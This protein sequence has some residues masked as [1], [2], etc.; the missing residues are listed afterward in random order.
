MERLNI[1]LLTYCYPP[2]KFPRSVQISHLVQYLRKDFNITVVTSEPENEGDPSLLSFTPLDNV[3]YAPKSNF[4]KIIERSKGHRIKKEI[5]PD[6]QYLWHFDLFRKAR[7]LIDDSSPDVIITFG[8]PMSTHIAGLKLKRKF[9]HIKWLAHF[10]DPWVDN[11]FNDY[12]AWTKWINK[13]YQDS[14]LKSA[15]R[16]IFTSQE[17]IDLVTKYYSEEVRKKSICLPHI[18]NQALYFHQSDHT[19]EKIILRYIGNFYGNRQP[20]SFLKALKLLS[21]EQRAQLRVEFIGSEAKSIKDII[22]FFKLEDTVFTYPAVSY[23]KSLE[24]MHSADILLIIDAPTEKSPFLPSKLIDYIGANKPIFGITPPGTSQKLIEE[25]GF[26]VADSRDVSDIPNKLMQM[27]EEFSKNKSKKVP[28]NIRHR[29]SIS[30]VGK[31]IKSILE[32][33]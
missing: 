1:L 14:V 24:L 4:T 28:S 25:M 17:T 20:D 19:N 12:N 13:Y 30:A 15:D 5:L 11:I 6:F 3:V 16:L 18:F 9:P 31:Q 22:S 32:N 2:Q 29:Y 10:S 26:L 33:V 27:I 8:H 23:I 21:H 7:V